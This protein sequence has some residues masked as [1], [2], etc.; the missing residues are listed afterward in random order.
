MVTLT[1]LYFILYDITGGFLLSHDFCSRP[2]FSITIEINIVDL[3]EP[4]Y[5]LLLHR[6]YI[7]KNI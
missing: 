4:F 2:T 6:L 7:C 5:W 3:N 1:L